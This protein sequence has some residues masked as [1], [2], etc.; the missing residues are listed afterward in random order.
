MYLVRIRVG[1][2]SEVDEVG[3]V[4]RVDVGGEVDVLDEAGVVTRMHAGCKACP[5][6][7]LVDSK[8]TALPDPILSSRKNS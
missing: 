6:Y 2:V 8:K 1:E 3:G 4:D 7:T 5:A